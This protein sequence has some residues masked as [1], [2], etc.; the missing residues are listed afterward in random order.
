M[1]PINQDTIDNGRSSSPQ[2]RPDFRYVDF[3]SKGDFTERELS[4]QTSK[5]CI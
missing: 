5:F 4:Y 2:A 1:A 3:S